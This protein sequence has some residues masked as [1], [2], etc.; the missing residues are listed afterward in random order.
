MEVGKNL[1]PPFAL[2][3]A[4]LGA[5]CG[6]SDSAGVSDEIE[7][8]GRPVIVDY[9]PTLSDVPALMFLATHPGVDLVAV[10]LP[11][12]GES[13]CGPGIRNTRALLA[14]AGHPDVP[15]GCGREEPMH[16]D[17]DWPE[18]FRYASNHLS[19][20]VLPGLS[21]Q[22]PIDAEDLL[23]R[24]L[25]RADDPVT[26]VALGP[27]TN[28]G[29]VLDDNPWLT[30]RVESVVS[31]GGAFDVPGNV[32]DAPDAEWNLY[33]DPESV[34]AVLDSGVPVIF[35]PL[36]ATNSVPGNAGTF[37]RLGATSTTDS[38][39]AVRQ[40]WAAN[41]DSI[42][43]DFWYFWDEL[44]AVVAVDPS[45]ATIEQ[46][47]VSMEDSGATVESGRGVV[48]SVAVAADQA[49]F[50]RVFLETF[51]GGALPVMGLTDA[52][53]EYLGRVTTA[54]SALND[55][56]GRI[57]LTIE[58]QMGE[59]P[60]DELMV[61]FA[62]DL[63]VGVSDLYDGLVAVDVPDGYGTAHGDL[64]GS[65]TA[66]LDSEAAFREAVEATATSD[67]VSL[68][69]FWSLFEQA[70][71]ESDIQRHFDGFDVA[72]GELELVAF[73]NGATNEICAFA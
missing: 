11:G 40:L 39:E 21:E 53:E 22:D 46:I 8:S 7:A 67:P 32:F 56:M 68:D 31:M 51:A 26:I 36:D 15:V 47:P 5:A 23:V 73:T 16:G 38:G 69:L 55:E 3:L 63:F 20:I 34:R 27:L 72:C 61:Q 17:R 50:E 52:E 12:T 44:A 57:F 42:T 54:M 30:D 35:V 28:L 6:D 33:I 43:S 71:V 37:A 2:A 65:V 60:A 45:V 10:T 25:R 24:T 18:E 58:E 19:G 59:V 13:D 66:I 70:A 48:A 4:V 1:V 9:S 29:L 14:V 41:L 49:R 64:V 62:T